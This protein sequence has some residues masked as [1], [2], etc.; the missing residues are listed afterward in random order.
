M[1]KMIAALIMSMAITSPALA[2]EPMFTTNVDNATS[3][4]MWLECAVP[5]DGD[6]NG[7]HTLSI[8]AV[9]GDGP[10]PFYSDM[11]DMSVIFHDGDGRSYNRAVQYDN[12]RL[13]NKSDK[14][15][16]HYAW[17]G[18]L[19]SNLAITM[20]GHLVHDRKEVT[21]VPD[22]KSDA[23]DEKW[24]YTEVMYKNGRLNHRTNSA[25]HVVK[26]RTYE[27]WVKDLGEG[28]KWH[29]DLRDDYQGNWYSEG[30][31]LHVYENYLIEHTDGR[32]GVLH[33]IEDVT[34]DGKDIRITLQDCTKPMSE[35]AYELERNYPGEL[36]RLNSLGFP[37]SCEDNGTKTVTLRLSDGYLYRMDN[38]LAKFAKFHRSDKK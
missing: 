22:E 9:I 31:D 28:L 11:T 4:E 6:R 36:S 26:Q 37:Y 35:W 12:T 29:L 10:E 2:K 33:D 32:P 1:K 15:V 25:C 3:Q 20:W 14:K 16:E 13:L 34:Y 7:P 8:Y 5:K 23:R 21:D 19:K 24:T 38:N 17:T 30:A 27:A 18:V